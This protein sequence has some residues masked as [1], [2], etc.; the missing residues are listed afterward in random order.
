MP[1][2]E[3]LRLAVQ[4]IWT[5][6]L[7][8]FFTLLGILVSVAFLI[9]VVAIIQ[10]MNSYVS[11]TLTASMIGTNTFQVRRG[12]ISVGLLDDEQVRAIAKRPLVTAQDAETVAQAV[13]D[14]VAVA[15]Q[16]GWPTPVGE[17]AYRDR[18]VINVTIFGITAAVPGGAGLHL[19]R[20]LAADRAGCERAAAGGGARPRDRGK[21]VRPPARGG[22][23]SGC[24]STGTSCTVKGV[25]APKGRLL[26]QSF[27][28]FVLLPFSTFEAAYGRRKTT[29]VSV[30]MPS[31]DAIEGGMRRA[32]EAMR[33]AHRL[34]P[35]EE[36]DFT[37]DKADA[38][39][40]FWK[41]LTSLLFT[42][43]PAVVA[44]GIVVGGIVIMNIMLMTVN[45]RTREIGLR[46][47]LGA[48]R[49]DIRRQF[50]VEALVLT[51]AGGALGVLTGWALAFGGLD[52]H[53][54]AR[55]DHA[56]VGR[57]RAGRGDRRRDAVRGLSR[58][59]G[60]AARPDRR[61]PGG[62]S[63]VIL[64]NIG[65]GV[66]IALDAIRSN[67]LR[68]ALTILGVVIGVTTVMA[69][70]SLVQGIRRQIFNAIEVAGPDHVLRHPL[71][72]PDPGQ[73]RPSALRGADPAG[74]PAQRRGGPPPPAGDPLRR[75]LGAGL[76][77]G[78]VPGRADPA[79]H[80]LRR[81]RPVH[82][83]PGRDAAPRPLLQPGRADRRAGHRAGERGGG[84]AVRPARS[85]GRAGPGRRRLLPGDR[86]LREAVQHLRA[87]GPGD[88]RRG[89][90]R[91]RPGELSIRRD[92]R[93]LHGGQ[94]DDPA[95]RSERR[96]TR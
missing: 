31:A 64:R 80:H 17:I 18:N 39:V 86:N 73:S 20:R 68:S 25:I 24:G 94:A 84:P 71:L 61:A 79:G 60:L 29:V 56:L 63:S 37:V 55:A 66:A 5:S 36:N 13:P 47:S 87:A 88:G 85:A 89:A 40:A 6:K 72:L 90:L 1:L 2:T 82:G 58:L 93:A 11:G 7:R 23:A 92:Q 10:G 83:D 28:A 77:E 75:H 43:I 78:G 26:G 42:A 34:R 22:R 96:W 14:A 3:A 49:A 44:I 19:S 35:G 59:A 74:P 15:L 76:P 91:D 50:L 45:E 9:V 70:A 57:A 53:A 38:F 41:Q 33:I 69:V 16:S 51:A 54:A 30:K 4:A 21:A 81:R 95:W 8:S 52:L 46:K 12:P 48:T 27:D 62:V 32:E 67:K 65:E